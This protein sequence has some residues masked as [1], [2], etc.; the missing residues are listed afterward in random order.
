[1]IV[2]YKLQIKKKLYK[3]EVHSFILKRVKYFSNT[4]FLN[5]I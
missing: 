4:I 3:K 1:M 2:T 5:D